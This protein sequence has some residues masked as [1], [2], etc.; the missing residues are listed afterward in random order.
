MS[1][2]YLGNGEKI[3]ISFF[4]NRNEEIIKDTLSNEGIKLLSSLKKELSKINL[5]QITEG[6]SPTELKT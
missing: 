1:T 5:D 3:S 2:I 4:R 6:Q